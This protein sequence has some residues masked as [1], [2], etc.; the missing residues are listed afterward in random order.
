MLLDTYT[1]F[2]TVMHSRSAAVKARYSDE[3][4][5][6]DIMAIVLMILV[7][8]ALAVIVNTLAPQY[9]RG[10]MDRVGNFINSF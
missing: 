5:I 1:R 9:L 6:T 8:V 3:R 2:I 7:A 4:G 10:V